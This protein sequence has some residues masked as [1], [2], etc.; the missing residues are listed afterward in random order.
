MIFILIVTNLMVLLY[1]PYW[2]CMTQPIH[3]GMKFILLGEVAIFFMKFF[4]YHHVW[5]DLRKFIISAN[6]VKEGKIKK[7][8]RSSSAH[9]ET[10]RLE[11]IDVRSRGN[12][13]RA[14]VSDEDLGDTLGISQSDVEAVL[15]YP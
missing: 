14:Q 1:V 13:F 11:E 9:D 10:P 6:S 2:W 7:K 12:R 8:K 5:H 4:S 15:T 3:M